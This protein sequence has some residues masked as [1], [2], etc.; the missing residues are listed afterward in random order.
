[1]LTV[2]FGVCT[3]SRTQVQLRYN[4]VKKGRRDVNDNARPGSPSTPTNDENIETGKKM[5]FDNRR[6]TIRERC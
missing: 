4:R 5:I 3:I 6:I 1:M 2:A